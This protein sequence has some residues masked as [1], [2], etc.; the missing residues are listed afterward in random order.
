MAKAAASKTSGKTPQKKASSK[1]AAKSAEKPDLLAEYNRKRDFKKT[2]EPAGTPGKA[3]SRTFMVQKHDATRLHY[4]LRLEKDGVLKSWAVTKG[5]SLDPDDKRLAVQTE[6]HPMSYATFEGTIPKGEYGGGTVML[7]DR[8]TWKPIEGKSA[9]DLE[10]GHLHFILEGERMKGE[11]LLVRMKRRAGE[12]RDNWLLR[13]LDDAHKGSSE[14]LT[15]RYLTSV[16]T[17]RTMEEITEGKDAPQKASGAS[18]KALGK[19]KS[20]SKAASPSDGPMPTFEKP[21]LAT[22]ADTVPPGDDWL[23]EMK[24]D[25]YRA[26]LAAADGDVRIYTRNG[27]DWT[28]NFPGVVAAA[29]DADLGNALLD[30]ELVVL[31]EQGRPDFQALQNSLGRG[32]K[33]AEDGVVYFAFD[34][35]HQGRRDLKRLP[36]VERKAHL[37]A[38]VPPEN[39]TLR[40]SDH[41]LGRGEALFDAMCDKGLEG[42]VSKRVDAPYRNRRTRDWLKVKCIRRQDFVVVGWTASSSAGR[43][44]A[45]LL[46]AQNEADGTMVYRGKV[47]TGWDMD[48]MEELAAK[49]RRLERKTPPLDVPKAAAKGVTWLTPKLVAE[50]AFAELTGEGVTRHASFLGL[51]ADKDAE[52]VT[53]EREVSAAAVASASSA[54]VKISSPDRVVFPDAGIT[55][56]GLADYVRAAAPLML[57][58]AARRPISLVRCPQGR[59]K[60]CFFQKHDAGS[61]GEHVHAVPILEKDGEKQDYL[62]VEDDAGL[63]ACVQMGTIEF[64]GWGSRVDDVEAPDRLVFDLDPDEGLDF[65]DVRQAALD[66]RDH[67]SDTG[68]VTFPM[69]TGG[70]GI[71]VIAPLSQSSDWTSVKDFASRFSRALAAAEP[72]RFTATMSKAKRKGRI[73]IDWLRNQRG[74]TAIMPYSPRAREGA[75]VAAPVAWNELKDFDGGN[76]FHV[77]DIETLKRRAASAALTGWGEAEQELPDA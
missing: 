24:Y 16:S 4:D 9:D 53:A 14:G 75:P 28:D 68:L 69:L 8:G 38:L 25:G 35:L 37:A 67:L 5:P 54:D 74:S 17:G 49:M 45:S 42:I 60:A 44:F 56:G 20:G 34:L 6:D 77:G 73:F 76:A 21:Q 22:L 3:G 23:H 30:G 39:E 43:P 15:G 66:I 52:D 70:K 36:L 2:A 13:K 58:F 12:K 55:K 19:G 62:Y 10:E 59:Q 48:K 61:F 63:L 32:K 27:K 40:Y 41:V 7:W 29:K 57:P 71:H 51:R 18:K 11:W 33:V 65:A 31:D 1:P 64:H 47:G 46:L 50:V 26:L 72:D